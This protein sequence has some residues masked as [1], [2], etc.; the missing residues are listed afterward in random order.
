MVGTD[1]HAIVGGRSAPA[2]YW[3]VRST[4]SRYAASSGT[5]PEIGTLGWKPP[6]R[7]RLREVATRHYLRL[8]VML[9]SLSHANQSSVLI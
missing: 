1:G 7:Q 8:Y 4:T 5:C 9:L 3:S 2:F 6:V